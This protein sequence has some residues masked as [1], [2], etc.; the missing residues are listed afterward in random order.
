MLSIIGSDRIEAMA[1]AQRRST[2]G[3][4][5]KRGL[6]AVLKAALDPEVAAKRADLRY[7]HDLMPRITRHKTRNG[8]NYRLPDGSLVRDIETPKRIR[9]LV[10]P[11]AWSD[12]WICPDPNGHLQAVGRD[13]RGR[14][15]YRYHPRWREVRGGDPI[16]AGASDRS[17][18]LVRS[19]RQLDTDRIPAAHFAASD[20]DPHHA[21]F[22]H[23]IAGI[24]PGQGRRH[25]TGLKTVELAAGIAQPGNFDDGALAEMKPGA[26][27]QSEQSD[28]ARC[29]VFAH[30]ARRKRQSRPA[31]ARRTAPLG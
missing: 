11:P 13:Q 4:N 5:K 30:I 16:S 29:D 8:F 6:V 20:D 7:V 15:Q 24:I 26:F 3:S 2:V 10:I 19:F 28:P 25:Q 23:E 14:K 22:A 1:S 17:E 18:P 12:V 31:S 9:A 27:R 21:G